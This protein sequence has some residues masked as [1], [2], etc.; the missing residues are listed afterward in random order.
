MGCGMADEQTTLD[1]LK[2]ELA[3]LKAAI[4]EDNDWHY[5]DHWPDGRWP[6]VQRLAARIDALTE[7][8]TS[9]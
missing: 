6:M 3:E 5:R 8:P 2:R 9:R 4:A 1:D 7:D